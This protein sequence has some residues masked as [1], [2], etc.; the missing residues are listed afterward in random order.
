MI[1]QS[2]AQTKEET[3]KWLIEKMMN[4]DFY[5]LK[6]VTKIH[7]V[8]FDENYLEIKLDSKIIER[9][10]N[11]FE[12]VKTETNGFY[13]ID[14]SKMILD[15]S[16]GFQTNGNNIYRE[17]NDFTIVSR[18]GGNDYL[19]D[20]KRHHHKNYTSEI[21]G[22]RINDNFEP[23]IKERFQKAIKH[24]QSLMTVKKS[25]EAF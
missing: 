23:N 2:Q 7:M 10:D 4:P 16:G 5:W 20:E 11:S 24:Y 6:R 12:R 8:K 21:Y 13:K 14:L 15:Y 19:F 1:T 25:N 9:G 3:V 18:N 22:I 17:E